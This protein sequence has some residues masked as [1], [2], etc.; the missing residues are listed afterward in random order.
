MDQPTS[1][2]T[3]L[4]AGALATG[5]CSGATTSQDPGNDGGRVCSGPSPMGETREEQTSCYPEAI[6]PSGR[7]ECLPP[8]D[9]VLYSRLLNAIFSCGFLI[10]FVIDASNHVP[11]PEACEPLV[12]C[13]FSIAPENFRRQECETWLHSP[14]P[15]NAR[16]CASMLNYEIAGVQ[17]CSNGTTLD[18]G[19]PDARPEASTTDGQRPPKHALCCYRTCGSSHCI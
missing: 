12:E 2:L 6:G 14:A 5:A 7:P 4:A 9:P 13:C 10:E 11:L 17:A 16:Y 15:I 8:N 19:M 3:W 18:S 1:L